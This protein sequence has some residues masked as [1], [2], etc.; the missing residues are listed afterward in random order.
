[1]ELLFT[2]PYPIHLESPKLVSVRFCS[3]FHF[4]VG[5]MKIATKR[6]LPFVSE[7]NF[8]SHYAA[9]RYV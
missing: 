8:Y 3:D 4:A 1:M 5:K 7:S 9:N 6:D 2:S